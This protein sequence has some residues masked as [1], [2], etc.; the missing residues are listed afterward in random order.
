MWKGLQIIMYLIIRLPH[1][2]LDG[3]IIYLAQTFN[4]PRRSLDGYMLQC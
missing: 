3:L 2:L 4:G 1:R